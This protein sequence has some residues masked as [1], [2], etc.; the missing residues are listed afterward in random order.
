MLH[1]IAC[2]F[3]GDLLQ[4]VD[5]FQILELDFSLL[6]LAG[7]PLFVFLQLL[8]QKL[9]D[10]GLILFSFGDQFL[11]LFLL[12]DFDFQQLRLLLVDL[13]VFAHYFVSHFLD[14]LVLTL[15]IYLALLQLFLLVLSC[16]YFCL[17]FGENGLEFLHLFDFA[18]IILF[19]LFLL[20]FK[21]DLFSMLIILVLL[22]VSQVLSSLGDLFV[23]FSD[24]YV[25]LLLGLLEVVLVELGL[26]EFILLLVIIPL[27]LG[28]SCLNFLDLLLQVVNAAIDF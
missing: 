3:V 14:Q 18:T 1:L 22:L 23:E 4:G 11:Q 20:L 12:D 5:L 24:A 6:V 7:L 13:L 27:L 10:S 21:S 25:Q 17:L 16:L 15:D 8:G 28:V 26:V 9:V 19:E 2:H